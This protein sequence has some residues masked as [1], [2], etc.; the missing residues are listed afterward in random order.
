[1]RVKDNKHADRAN[2]NFLFPFEQKQHG[3]RA[4][5]A[6]ANE[7]RH[8]HLLFLL[9]PLHGLPIRGGVAKLLEQGE[10]RRNTFSA[11]FVSCGF[12]DNCR[13]CLKKD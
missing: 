1:M 4:R 7:E 10:K 13:S 9:G 8:P 12:C 3:G 2:Q 5:E 11:C 6:A